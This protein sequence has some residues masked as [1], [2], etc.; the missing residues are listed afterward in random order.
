MFV[1]PFNYYTKVHPEKEIIQ[2]NP[3]VINYG[4]LFIERKRRK[5][6]LK[7]KKMRSETI[8]VSNVE[9]NII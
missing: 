5:R 2:K 4:F 7:I 1:N 6:N 3:Q 8:E 9:L